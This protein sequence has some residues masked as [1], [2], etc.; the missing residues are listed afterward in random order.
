M[1]ASDDDTTV[2]RRRLRSQLLT[3]DRAR[4]PDAV[5]ERLLAV[6]AQDPRGFR[7]AVRSRSQGV[8]ATDVD[9]ALTAR[10]MV[11][12]WLNRG[13]L[14]LV[15]SDDYRWLQALTAPRTAPAV[16][17][18][19]RQLGVDPATEER[20]VATVADALGTEG[21][22][23]RRALRDRLDREGVPTAGQALVHLLAAASLRGLIVRGPVVDGHHAFVAVDDWLGPPPPPMTRDD[24]LA[25]L[26]R[27]YLAGHAPAGPADLAA[28]AGITLGD[29]RR[30]LATVD[31]GAGGSADG[32]PTGTSRTDP[33]AVGGVRLLGPF[34]P[35]LHGWRHRDLFVGS[36]GSVVTTNGIFRATCLVDDRIV[37]TWTVPRG[38]VA[39]DLFERVGPRARAALAADAADVVAFL[40]LPGSEPAVSDP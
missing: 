13:T 21:P 38:R 26:A 18:R 10:R 14:H 15:R 27:R 33:P 11:V 40:G 17:R 12:T 16:G 36:H 23:D 29:A 31:P 4:S 34:D 6:Q 22:L 25:L 20:G 9:A 39:I 2:R 37:G 35:L 5:V 19:L 8:T 3:G 32:S 28:W 1:T 30:A 24:T 7:L